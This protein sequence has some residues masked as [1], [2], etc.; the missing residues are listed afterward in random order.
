MPQDSWDREGLDENDEF[1]CLTGDCPPVL[2]VPEVDAACTKVTLKHFGPYGQQKLVFD[3]AVVAPDAYKNSVLQMF[4]RFKPGWKHP[5]VGSKLFKV[6][7]VAVGELPRRRRVT[8]SL[9]SDKIYR[10]RLKTV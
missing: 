8:K 7:A 9:F 6:I 1:I 3:F 4:V 2:P 10:C 5:P